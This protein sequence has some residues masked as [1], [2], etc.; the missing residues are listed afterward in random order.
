[1]QFVLPTHFQARLKLYGLDEGACAQL[2]KLWPVIEPGIARAVDDFIEAEKQ[3]P[4]VAAI[5]RQHDDFIRELTLKHLRLLLSGSLDQRYAE[6]SQYVS[7]QQYRIGLTPRT[8][9]IA[10][11][12]VQRAAFDA[13]GRKFRFSPGKIVR[14][15]QVVSQALAFDIAITLTLYQDAALNA[16]QA[17]SQQVDRA[18]ADFRATINDTIGAVKGVSDALTRGSADMRQAAEDTSRSMKSTAEASSATTSVMKQSAAAAE[19]LSQ[20]I[21]E[22]G[23]QS[24]G[25]LQLASNAARDAET[26]LQNLAALSDAV[27]KIQSVAGMISDIA[28]QTNLLALNATIEAARAGDAGKGFAVV[29]GEVKALANQT[30]KATESISRQIA[31]IR[32]ASQDVSAQLGS[33]AQAV[34]DIAAMAVRIASSVQEQTAA[35]RDIASSVQAAAQ[36]TVQASENVRTVEGSTSRSLDIVQDVVTLSESLSSRAAD[37]EQKVAAFFESVRAA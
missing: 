26:S 20:S 13:L 25:S 33:A 35:T 7:E 12:M 4:T 5:F 8:Q 3:M 2:A 31:A 1:M 23:V 30:E 37:L 16:S 19:Q 29:A 28:G 6:S 14:G 36:Y 27:E 15:G 24:S 22:I 21:E 18:I 9:M 10:S 32:T 34:K 11:N 17:R